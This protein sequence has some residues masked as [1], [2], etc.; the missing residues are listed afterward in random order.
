MTFDRMVGIE[1]PE[2]QGTFTCDVC[3]YDKPHSHS[4]FDVIQQRFVCKAFEER[5]TETVT[6]SW[7]G[8]VTKLV[9]QRRGVRPEDGY[10][11]EEHNRKWHTYVCAWLDA[12]KHFDGRIKALDAEI[13]ALR[14]TIRQDAHMVLSRRPPGLQSREAPQSD[15]EVKP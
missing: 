9:P 13:A 5:Y 6:S 10:W 12:W 4:E 7:D 14:L 3:G 1:L 15:G 2:P 8:D 11:G